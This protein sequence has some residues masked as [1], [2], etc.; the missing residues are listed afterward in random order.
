M[1]KSFPL[2]VIFLILSLIFTK[3]VLAS[4]PDDINQFI[5]I[6]NPIRVSNYTKDLPGSFESQYQETIKRN[7]PA[8][9]LITFDALENPKMT[10][11]LRG[12][13][14]S[15]EIGI[16]FE[17]SP[18]F[19]D[20]SSV[21][22]NKT[23]SWHR[24]HALFL[25]GY[26]QEDRKKLIDT[27]FEKF[28]QELGFYPKSVGAWWIDSYS[29]DYMQKKYNIIANLGLAD[30]FEVDGYQVWGQYWST[31]FIPNKYHAGIPANNLNNKLNLVTIEW[32]SRDPLNGYGRIPANNY[33]TQDY[34]NINLTHEYF[35]KLI[36]LYSSKNLNRFGHITIG[37]ET[38][39]DPDSYQNFYAN[40]LDIAKTKNVKFLTMSDFAAWYLGNYKITPPQT[41]ISDDLLG[42]QKKVIWY[43]SS[44]YRLGIKNDSKQSITEIFDFRIYPQ[45][46][47]EPNYYSPNKQLNLFINLPSVIDQIYYPDSNWIISRNKLTDITKEAD[48]LIIKFDNQYIKFSESNILLHNLNSL[49]EYLK[50]SPLLKIE[51]RDSDISITPKVKYIVNQD[52]L[53]IRGLSIK[54]TYFLM[55]PKIQ[56]LFKTALVLV[57]FILFIFLKLRLKKKIKLI[58]LAV[59][60]VSSITLGFTLLY[61]NS[62]LYEVSQSEADALL[63]LSALPK[64]KVIVYDGGCLI[65]PWHTKYPPPFFANNRGYV[66]SIA[67]KEVVYNSK[68]FKAAARPEGRQELKRL[69]AKYIYVVK[70]ENYQESL[71][72][73]PGDY[74]IDLVYEN[75]NAQIWKVRDNAPY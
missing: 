59:F 30:Q 22:Y 74:F 42:N 48:N 45:T 34:L 64:G 39:L 40:Q 65:C 51:N 14:K 69:R 53:L 37:L 38:D 10:S 55:R 73:S 54:S 31:P 23:D 70:F 1:S 19:A 29:L 2:I 11:I 6:V 32:A 9:W 72:F 27:V 16:F 41:I 8:T 3:N 28:K 36:S 68:I 62:Q 5:T 4:E 35:S 63:H 71:P 75:A 15:Q 61:I 50:T 17:V 57:P 58:I 46:F 24:A 21:E 33:S 18:K 49:P 26:Q 7:L 12:I 13:D 25:S 44:F 52:G 20:K 43:Q 66:Q 56:L 60:I 67:K 47:M